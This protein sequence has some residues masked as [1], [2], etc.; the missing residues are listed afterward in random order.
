MLF[1]TIFL[2][3]YVCAI[4]KQNYYMDLEKVSI[5]SGATLILNI[6]VMYYTHSVILSHTGSVPVIMLI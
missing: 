2:C 6:H 3:V 5:I 1:Y 4:N